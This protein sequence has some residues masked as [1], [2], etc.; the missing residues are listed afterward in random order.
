MHFLAVYLHWCIH[1]E[2]K[3]FLKMHTKCSP[4]L[5]TCYLHKFETTIGPKH[6]AVPNKTPYSEV[7]KIFRIF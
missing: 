2:K 1:E 5:Y 3:D 4:S 6:S 7:V